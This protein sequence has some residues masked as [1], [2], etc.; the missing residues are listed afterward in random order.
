MNEIKKRSTPLYH[1]TV[2]SPPQHCT[3]ATHKYWH[4]LER[5]LEAHRLRH[6]RRGVPDLR[7]LEQRPGHLVLHTSLQLALLLPVQALLDARS[8]LP[9]RGLLVLAFVVG[10]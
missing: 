6:Q 8:P 5:R 9:R 2:S 1:G 10:A 4:L 7:L 3:A